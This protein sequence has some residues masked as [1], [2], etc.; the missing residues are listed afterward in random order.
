MT[1]KIPLVNVLQAPENGRPGKK[2]HFRP[3]KQL[4]SHTLSELIIAGKIYT[5]RTSGYFQKLRKILSYALLAT[6]FIMPWVSIAQQPAVYFD[7]AAQKFHILG[8]TFWPQDAGFLVYLLVLACILLIAATLVIGRAWCG[9]V[10]PQT[11]W[12]FLFMW[13]ED[14]CE[15]DRN[16]RIKLD[17]QPWGYNKLYRKTAKHSLWLLISLITAYTFVGYFYPIRALLGDTISLDVH[18]L[19]VF[20]LIFFVLGTYLNAGWLREKVCLH[21]CPY[22]RFQAVMYTQDTLVI[23]Y[24]SLRGENRGH[25]KATTDTQALGLGDC[26]DC[27]LCVQ[28]CPV[29]IDIRDGMQYPCIDCGLCA[30]VCD[31]VMTKMG[32]ATGLIRF[33]S[34]SDPQGHKSLFKQRKVVWLAMLSLTL[35]IAFGYSLYNREALSI[36]VIRD[37]GANLYQRSEG[38]ILNT[39][40]VNINNKGADAQSFVLS[41]TSQYPFEIRG[42]KSIYVPRGKVDTLL[43][44]V[45]IDEQKIQQYRSDI[46]FVVKPK[47]E[48]N[49]DNQ[50]A[51]AKQLSSFIAPVTARK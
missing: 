37:R 6:F 14:K 27:S 30:D 32:Y 9:F 42:K 26:V 19:G 20:W 34:A 22:A 47:T 11:V 12:S 17:N 25:R 21:M 16:R 4:T 31:N 39:Y 8:M 35:T 41:L 40:Q 43:V 44:S 1:E 3:Q 18:Y 50:T 38:G 15:G 33:A 5:K 29:D 13:V 2:S 46:H 48:N 51:I 7:L 10:C 23:S 28:V 24:D 49:L 45:W 36:D